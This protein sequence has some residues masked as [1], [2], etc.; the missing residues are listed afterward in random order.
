MSDA[1]QGLDNKLQNANK[2]LYEDSCKTGNELMFV[3]NVIIFIPVVLLRG[4]FMT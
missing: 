2:V 1:M 4:Q 3:S